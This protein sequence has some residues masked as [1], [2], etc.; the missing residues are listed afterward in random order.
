MFQSVTSMNKFYQ[1]SR[2]FLARYIRNMM[3]EYCRMFTAVKLARFFR[4]AQGENIFLFFP[5]FIP[6][7]TAHRTDQIFRGIDFNAKTRDRAEKSFYNRLGNRCL[8]STNN[9]EATFSPRLV[10][11]LNTCSRQHFLIVNN[12]YVIHSLNTCSFI[13]AQQR[14]TQKRKNT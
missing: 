5:C 1:H 6:S 13:F 10:S 9:F 12:L 2:N 3:N 11:V 8:P 14:E 7:Q 4:H